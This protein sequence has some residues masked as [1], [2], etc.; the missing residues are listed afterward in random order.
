VRKNAASTIRFLVDP[1]IRTGPAA[2]CVS[3]LYQI[4]NSA[5]IQSLAWSLTVARVIAATERENFPDRELVALGSGECVRS[6]YRNERFDDGTSKR[7]GILSDRNCV[8]SIGVGPA[9]RS[10][11]H[12]VRPHREASRSRL[13]GSDH[14]ATALESSCGR[15]T[16]P[17]GPVKIA[18]VACRMIAKKRARPVARFWRSKSC[19]PKQ[20]FLGGR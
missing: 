16:A 5:R 8:D 2:V 20:G 14:S 3:R 9:P 13:H 19:S 6:C 15:A 10:V 18:P 7:H 12:M 11:L 4:G 1:P 17:Y